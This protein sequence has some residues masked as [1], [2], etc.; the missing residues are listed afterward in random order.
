MGA[1]SS[2]EI[3]KLV[4]EVLK[5]AL[6]AIKAA[7]VAADGLVQR[8]RA[9][10]AGA[11]RVEIAITH[12]GD[13]NSFARDLVAAA[14]QADLREAVKTGKVTFTL[15]RY[16]SAV[17][18]APARPAHRI[19]KGLVTEMMVTEIGR[20]ANRIVVGKGVVVTPL[21]RDKARELKIEIVRDRS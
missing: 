9:A 15:A 7:P 21:G 1:I 10:L 3:R 19:D 12:D 4:R 20:S 16:G 14:E 18:A 6:P 11:K 13:L 2:E 17:H 8:I 5:D